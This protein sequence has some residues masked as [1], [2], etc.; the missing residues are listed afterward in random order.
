MVTNR[1]T[2]RRSHRPSVSS[3]NT[4]EMKLQLEVKVRLFI[5][6]SPTFS[7]FCKLE[8]HPFYRNYKKHCKRRRLNWKRRMIRLVFFFLLAI[9]CKLF[10]LEVTVQLSSNLYLLFYA[11]ACLLCLQRFI[12]IASQLRSLEELVDSLKKENTVLQKHVRSSQKELQSAITPRASM[13]LL[14]SPHSA[15]RTESNSGVLNRKHQEIKEL[16]KKLAVLEEE[17]KALQKK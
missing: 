12:L 1:G 2:I 5:L 10:Q 15:Q 4:E 9:P 17:N 13:S 14:A 11:F 3:S 6:V 8:T 16:K 7:F